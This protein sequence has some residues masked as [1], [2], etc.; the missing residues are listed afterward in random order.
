MSSFE[1]TVLADAAYRVEGDVTLLDRDERPIRSR[2][3]SVHLCRCGRSASTPF[4]D[5]SHA[6]TGWT[7]DA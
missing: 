5:I 3:S 4:C 2:G 1:I 7:D 6:R